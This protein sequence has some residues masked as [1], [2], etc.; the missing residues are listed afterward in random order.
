[1]PDSG[2]TVTAEPLVARLR[3]FPRFGLLLAAWILGAATALNAVVVI[4]PGFGYDAHAYWL[5]GRAA[6]PYGAAPGTFNAYLYSPVFAQLIRPL[7][8]L[9]WSAFV[10]LWMLAEATVFVWLT[11]T[12]PLRWRIPVLLACVPEVLM[13]NVYGYLAVAAVLGA[14]RPIW[15]ALPLLTK[16]TPGLL[17]LLW[18]AAQ[19]RWRD[20]V[21]AIAAT[22][23]IAAISCA[24]EPQLWQEWLRFLAHSAGEARPWMTMRT[25]AAAVLVVFAARRRWPWLLPAAMLLGTPMLGL[26]TKNLAILA[27][28]PRLTRH[29]PRTI[30]TA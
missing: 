24:A 27:A 21:R 25:A 17:G 12:L 4:V 3:R 22:V 28:V 19:R 16:I 10:A 1:M 18:L 8:L 20:L 23:V 5:A 13:G 26:S 30:P 6:H 29:P 7:A 11:A 14:R 15:W 9:P 2:G